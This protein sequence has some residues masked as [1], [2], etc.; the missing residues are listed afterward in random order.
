MHSLTDSDEQCVIWGTP[1]AMEITMFFY[2]NQGS[3]I[4]IMPVCVDD[5]VITGDD[6]EEIKKLK[7]RLGR[8]FEV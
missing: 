3:R 1:N 2:R 7:E 4:T 8:A 6:V 5:I